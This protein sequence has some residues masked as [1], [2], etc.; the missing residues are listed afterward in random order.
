MW[1]RP[2]CDNGYWYCNG[3]GGPWHGGIPSKYDC[4]RALCRRL[5]A[6]LPWD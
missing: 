2:L 5:N 6:P 1:P 3:C 4:I